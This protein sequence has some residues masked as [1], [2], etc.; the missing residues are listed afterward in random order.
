VLLVSTDAGCTVAAR[1][2]GETVAV[3]EWPEPPRVFA[4]LFR[5]ERSRLLE[6]LGELGASDWDRPTPCPGWSVLGLVS[7]LL[8]DD[9]SLVASQRD[10]HHGT[11]VP[12]GLDEHGFITWLDELQLEWVQA[13][14]RL[15]PRLVVELLGWVGD[16]VVE[17]V[18][19]Q[20][21]SA[22]TATVTWASAGAVPVWLDQVRE[23]SER[24]IHRQQLL[25]ALGRA[26]DLRPDLA[27]PVLDGLRWAYPYRLASIHR[28]SGT[29]VAI[30][31]TGPEVQARWILVSDGEAWR[32]HQVHDGRP[33]AELQMTTEQAWRLLTNNFDADL[34]GQLVG[35]GNHE[36]VGALRRTRAIIGNPK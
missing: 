8:G 5:L 34:H 7:H 19:G 16:Q 21:P 3:V 1:G 20:D 14:R 26:S 27:G 6:L 17:T 9:L 2:F 28:G 4:P 25:Q 15:S 32:F 10:D 23:L 30:T 13:A 31:V 18:A 22:R 36:I 29:T 11:P 24:W 12:D 33:S 35:A